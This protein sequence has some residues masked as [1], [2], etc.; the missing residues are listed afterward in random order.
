MWNLILLRW[1][2]GLREL[3]F[4]NSGVRIRLTDDRKAEQKGNRILL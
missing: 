4:L 2:T 3:A 1:K